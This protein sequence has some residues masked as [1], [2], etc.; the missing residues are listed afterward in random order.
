MAVSSKRPPTK[1]PDALARV[2]ATTPGRLSTSTSHA[3]PILIGADLDTVLVIWAEPIVGSATQLNDCASKVTGK[4][5]PDG[6]LRLDVGERVDTLAVYQNQQLTWY[7]RQQ[8]D[9][10]LILRYVPALQS[11]SGPNQR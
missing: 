9:F 7:F 10:A 1:L 6:R 11:A 8:S 4:L 3:G 2:A 5:I